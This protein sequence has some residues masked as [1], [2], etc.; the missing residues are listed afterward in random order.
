MKTSSTSSPSEARDTWVRARRET[1][2]SWN[3]ACHAARREARRRVDSPCVCHDCEQC[4]STSLPPL[5]SSL[6]A[7]SR[8][9]TTSRTRY[10]PEV[11]TRAKAYADR[12]RTIAMDVLIEAA[13]S[14]LC[15]WGVLAHEKRMLSYS[16]ASYFLYFVL[17]AT[18]SAQ[19][20]L[21]LPEC[22]YSRHRQATH[23]QIV[24]K[25]RRPTL[26]SKSEV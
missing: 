18:T 24:G 10:L 8:T 19:P 16:T 21:T 22:T 1:Q 9:K 2:L 25:C 23:A 4:P 15:V 26:Q 20:P 14:T 6:R 13:L 17:P 5:S 3:V 11:A 7:S 12:Y